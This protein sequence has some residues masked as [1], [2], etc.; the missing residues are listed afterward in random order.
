MKTLFSAAMRKAGRLTRQ[1]NVIEATEVIK[2]ALS[3]RRGA[4]APDA[5]SPDFPRTITLA[6][7][8]DPSAAQGE[9]E[10]EIALA[11][12]PTATAA[13][14]D[15][16]PPQQRPSGRMKRP[17]GEVLELLRKVDLPDLARAAYPF[18]TPRA[19]PSTPQGA[20]FLSRTFACPAGAR[21]YKVYVPA[22][23]AERPANAAEK[24]PLLVMLHGCSQNPDDFA[25][26]TGM[27][28]LAEEH[29]FI[30][31][32]PRQS[33]SANQTACWNWFNPSDQMRDAGEPS[34]ISGMTRAVMADFDIDPELVFVAGLSAGGAMAAI[35]SATYPEL[36][37]ASGIHSG[38]AHGSAS[39]LLS[40]L[41]AMR[42]RFGPAT[43]AKAGHPD[44]AAGVRTI[45]FHGAM[46]QTVHPSNADA[47][48]LAA[49]AGLKDAALE[50]QY[51]QSPGGCAYKR[52]V[53]AGASGVPHVEYWAIEGL[54]HAWSGGRPEGSY[55][56]PRGPDAS[57]EMLRFFL[58]AP[59]E[60]E[61]R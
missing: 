46:D 54:G 50:T 15:D 22:Q 9:P 49:R 35:M 19:T 11:T 18:A 48:V 43:A 57:R 52:T 39:D 10:G 12:A 32:Y 2:R 41:T 13:L 14:F 45:V 21:D 56:D 20:A 47:I 37:R 55:T 61:A 42:G 38:L 25:I 6:S 29:G 60:V 1:Q 4:A 51:G 5:P 44:G 3:G 23:V 33:T 17:L 7:M 27:N 28:L 31:A 8:L 24:R 16:A 30:V 36:Y 34:I 26:G 53:I 59:A 40:A 58:D